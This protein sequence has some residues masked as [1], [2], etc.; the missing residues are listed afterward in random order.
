MNPST[1]VTCQT[2][3][4]TACAKTTCVPT[5]VACVKAP[6]AKGV[7]CDDGSPCTSNDQC[8]GKGACQ[9]GKT[10]VCPCLQDLDCKGVDDGDLCNGTW[11][12]DKGGKQ[13]LCVWNPAT[14]VTCPQGGVCSTFVCEPTTGQCSEKPANTGVQCDDG[15]ACTEQ[16]VSAGT[17]CKGQPLACMQGGAVCTQGHCNVW[18]E[19][20]WD[21]DPWGE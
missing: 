20:I 19:A 17:A 6:V 1:I 15:D 12:C 8:D 2:V 18:D 11:Y 5:T 4:D 14:V 16:D 10:V 13:P 9:A 3:G 21:L 7:G